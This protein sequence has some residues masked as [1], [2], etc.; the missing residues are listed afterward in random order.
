MLEASGGAPTFCCCASAPTP[1]TENARRIASLTRPDMSST[2]VIGQSS[3][4][5]WRGDHSGA[6]LHCTTLAKNKFARATFREA[7]NA[8]R[9]RQRARFHATDGG[10]SAVRPQPRVN[11]RVPPL[12][13]AGLPPAGPHQ[14]AVAQLFDHLVGARE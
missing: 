10:L 8:S 1:M 13:W 3:L 2:Q 4:A 11:E 12:P 7:S 9:P 14:L 5:R 6:G